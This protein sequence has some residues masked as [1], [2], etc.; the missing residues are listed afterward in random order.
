MASITVQRPVV[1]KAIVTEAFKRLYVADLEEAIK[2]VD[3][4]VQQIDVQSR[5]V[6]LERQV[7]PQTRNIRAQLEMERQRQEGTRIELQARLREAQ[8]LQ[9]NTEFLQGT[10]E[11]TV[12]VSVGDNLFDK[13]SRTEII[14]KDGIVLEI[15]E[16]ATSPLIMPA[17]G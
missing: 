12:D 9:L 14:V 15:R 8:D 4:I 3:A 6:E 13:I 2:R 11:G 7:S 5:R 16:T 1:I 10:I 17:G